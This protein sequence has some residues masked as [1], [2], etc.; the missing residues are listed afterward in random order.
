MNTH[1]WTFARLIPR[2]MTSCFSEDF[3][4]PFHNRIWMAQAD[5][6]LLFN[7]YDD[8]ACSAFQSA[9]KPTDYTRLP[10]SWNQRSEGASALHVRSIMIS[11]SLAFFDRSLSLVWGSISE[12][13]P[14]IILH[15]SG[16]APYDAKPYVL[17]SIVNPTPTVT[18]SQASVATGLRVILFS[19]GGCGR[20]DVNLVQVPPVAAVIVGAAATAVSIYLHV[21]LRTPIMFH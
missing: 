2:T 1:K 9:C 16:T 14:T 10:P 21:E 17:L 5:I 11:W 3:L 15:V 18:L 20:I 4:S 8:E 12:I 7:L 6:C 13:L 19:S